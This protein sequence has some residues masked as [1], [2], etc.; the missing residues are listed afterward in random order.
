MD[1]YD[2]TNLAS[3]LA[4][5]ITYVKEQWGNSVPINCVLVTDGEQ[6]GCEETG[7]NSSK[8]D[9]ILPFS[10]PGTLS[11]MCINHTDNPYFVK[12]FN[13]ASI[14]LFEKSDLDGDTYIINEH[15]ELNRSSVE[16]MFQQLIDEKYRPFV[17]TLYYGEDLSCAVT[18]CPP[19]MNYKERRDFETIE[20]KVSPNLII[21]G[22]L[23]TSDVASPPVVSRHLV[24]THN[25][26]SGNV[27]DGSSGNSNG[28]TD[29]D[30]ASRTPSL[31][32]FL[33]GAMKVDSLCALVQVA[34][35]CGGNKPL[36]N[37]FG[38]LFTYA[39]T[40]KK[41]S[42]MLALLEPGDCPVP[43]MGNI[44]R[45]GPIDELTMTSPESSSPFPVKASTHRPSYSSSP[46]VWIK[47]ASL[48]SDIQKILRHARKLPDKSPHFYKELNRLKRAALC[49]GFHELLEGCASIF[50]REC[51]LLSSGSHGGGIP[52]PEC[53][54]HL[55]HAASE[56]RSRA[57]LNLDY[58]IVPLPAT[59]GVTIERL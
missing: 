43:W 56:L 32:V 15:S 35:G 11:V 33:H 42:L 53:V 49:I 14:A 3:G 38:L 18:L 59:S 39:D 36:P 2:T 12:R 44:R 51:A 10:F 19:P 58:Q 21:K 50:D 52:H 34:E 17:G 6:L 57:V 25:I 55:R 30:L 7:S 48:H 4:G 28:S 37:W 26:N 31:C 22:M 5:V 54:M 45:L 29:A 20:A 27:S 1:A 9:S 41:S 8:L 23:S 47:H 46:V 13:A 24:L 16:S 40:K